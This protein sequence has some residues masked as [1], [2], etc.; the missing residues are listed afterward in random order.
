LRDDEEFQHKRDAK[1]WQIEIAE[2]FASWL[3]RKLENDKLVMKDAEY[4]E[5]F[6]LVKEK[7]KREL[8]DFAS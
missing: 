7:F 1:D 6:G 4:R 2:R 5:W 8:E 3:N